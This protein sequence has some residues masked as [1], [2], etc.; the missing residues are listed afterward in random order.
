MSRKFDAILK[1]LEKVSRRAKRTSSVERTEKF[2]MAPEWAKKMGAIHNE[3]SHLRNGLENIVLNWD[4]AKFVATKVEHM[5][6]I[7]LTKKQ[8]SNK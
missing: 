5:G 2:I 1:N 6:T 4:T 8:E 7:D 3:L